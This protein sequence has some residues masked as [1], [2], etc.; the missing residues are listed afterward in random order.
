LFLNDGKIRS[1]SSPE[2]A[3]SPAEARKD[4]V[5]PKDFFSFFFSLYG[6]QIRDFGYRRL[7]K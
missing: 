2:A 3:E 1:S 7:R 6:T 5:F 4:Y